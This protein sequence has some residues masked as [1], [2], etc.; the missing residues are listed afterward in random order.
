MSTD[1]CLGEVPESSYRSRTGK[2]SVTLWL[3]LRINWCL[4]ELV[5]LD[6]VVSECHLAWHLPM[7]CLLGCSYPGAHAL[8]G[9]LF[10]IYLWTSLKN[11]PYFIS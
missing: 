10:T 3:G 9:C 2:H 4:F 8:H 7:G 11:K 1:L 5:N 6:T